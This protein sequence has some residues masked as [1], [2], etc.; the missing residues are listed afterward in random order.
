MVGGGVDDGTVYQLNYGT[1]DVEESI[2]LLAA[3]VLNHKARVI[4]LHEILVRFAAQLAGSVLLSVYEN[5]R[6][7]FTRQ[8]TMIPERAGDISRRHRITCDVTS[9]LMTLEMSHSSASEPLNI[10]DIGM[11]TKVWEPK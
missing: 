1:A 3:I 4:N 7:K 9:D 6:L 8:L 2:R 5:E 11:A 10:F